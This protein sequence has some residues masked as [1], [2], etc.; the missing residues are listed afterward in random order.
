[1]NIMENDKK[2]E[3]KKSLHLIKKDDGFIYEPYNNKKIDIIELFTDFTELIL[4][5]LDRNKCFLYI[6]AEFEHDASKDTQE[7][8]TI[9]PPTIGEEKEIADTFDNYDERDDAEKYSG[10][11]KVLDRELDDLPM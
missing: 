1:M 7:V 5:M 6:I 2:V 4:S 8:F 9:I 3:V 11:L 10:A